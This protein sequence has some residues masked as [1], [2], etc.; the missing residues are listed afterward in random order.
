MKTL[1]II[2]HAHREK[3]ADDNGLSPKGRKQAKR[4]RDFYRSRFRRSTAALLSSPKR[5]CVETLE[6]L[7]E[8][9]DVDI[10]TTA[11]LDEGDALKLRAREFLSH[12]LA[13][14]GPELTVISS[15]GDWI[16]VFLELA[17]GARAELAKGGWAEIEADGTGVPRLSWLV[18]EL[19]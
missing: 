2:R 6:P 19:S 8:L 4:A 14:S 3:I 10:E 18:Q 17:T 5:R 7:S 9:L 12:W 16:P 1:I 15:H 13:S 11:L